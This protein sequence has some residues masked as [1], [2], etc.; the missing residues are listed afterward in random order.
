MESFDFLVVGGGTAALVVA[1]RISEDSGQRVLVLEA[2]SDISNDPRVQT[3]AFYTSLQ[4]TDADWGFL[5]VPQ[6]KLDGR[7]MSLSQ[8]KA[9]GGSSVINAHVF[10]PPTQKIIDTWDSLGNVGW[11]WKSMEPYY[12]KAFTLPVVAEALKRSLAIDKWTPHQQLPGGPIKL[13]FPGAPDHPL[14]EAWAESFEGMGRLNADGPWG[15]VSGVGAFSNLA[16]IDPEERNRCHAAN[17]YYEPHKDRQN[18]QILT[19]AQ[20]EKVIFE[21]GSTRAIGVQYRLGTE[22]KT[23]FAKKEVI[24]A[25]GALQT[26]KLLELS[27]IGDEPTLGSLGIRTIKHLAGVGENLQDHICCA[28]GY[29]AA[30][31]IE[32]LDS[33]LRQEPAAI[34]E[35]ME[36]FTVRRAGLLTSSGILTYAYMS[37]PSSSS[38]TA[39]SRE[40]LDAL[41]RQ[42]TTTA[43]GSPDRAQKREQ[44]YSRVAKDALTDPNQP[45]AAYLAAIGQNPV[46]VDPATREPLTPLPG[47]H[48]SLAAI[49]SHPVARGSVHI[50]SGDVADA[51]VIDP[52]YLAEPMDEQ[53][54]A[55]HVLYLRTV[56]ALP[57]MNRVLKHPPRL[58]RP[59]C[60]LDTLEDVKRYIS[61]HSISM[62]HPAGTCAMLPEEMDGVVDT[63]LTVYG[64]K[65]LRVVDAS[66]V[67][68]LP[69]GNLQSTV[70]A[71]A[72]RAAD[73]VKEEYQ[74][75]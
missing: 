51:P 18:L 38:M 34:A 12:N 53:V 3:P 22:T 52:R 17:A 29:E 15:N 58:S 46:A 44:A 4:K 45:S 1:S 10:A 7:L 43:D 74:I 60:R 64:T 5:T 56:A 30:D 69:P 50:Q 14:R 57:A 62:W 26:P 72:E 8:G 11:N 48:V 24:L 33:L 75:K 47:R 19:N 35:A 27:G 59:E 23:V 42:G 37:L 9:L 20:V 55:E 54:F 21:P 41:L 25:A 32:T 66:V 13:S 71:V 31:E 36:D 6:P 16:S 40:L 68:L 65:G 2:G 61:H 49:L 39:S 67:P 28:I 73:I 70:Y 63:Q